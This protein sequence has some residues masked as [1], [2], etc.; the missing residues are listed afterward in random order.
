[1]TE[2][3]GSGKGRPRGGIRD[4][5][6]VVRNQ[7]IG[8]PKYFDNRTDSSNA[9]IPHPHPGQAVLELGREQIREILRG[10]QQPPVEQVAKG[11]LLK[12]GEQV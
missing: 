1:M 11:S 7:V 10:S 5:K 12:G 9:T 4:G 2:H 6:A 8:I 3:F